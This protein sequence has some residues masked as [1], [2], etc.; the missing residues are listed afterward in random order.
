MDEGGCIGGFIL[1]IDCLNEEIRGRRKE[2]SFLSNV[3]AAIKLR[4]DGELPPS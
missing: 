3:I 2:D 4:I 1:G